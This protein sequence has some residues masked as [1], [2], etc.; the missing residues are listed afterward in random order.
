MLQGVGKMSRVIGIVSGKGGVGKTFFAINLGLALTEIG[1]N[2]IVADLDLKTSSLGLQL[3]AYSFP[4]TIQDALIGRVNILELI[5]IHPSGLRYIPASVSLNYNIDSKNLREIIS[6]L[7]SILL[8][9][10]P[11]GIGEEVLNIIQSCDELI[12]VTNPEVHAVVQSMKIAEIIENSGKSIL[13]LVVNR[14][15]GESYELR[16]EEIS[17]A[18]G[19]KILSSIPED[20]NVIK[21][22]WKKQP[23]LQYKPNSKVSVEFKKLACLL[24][25]KTY[26][27]PRFLVLRGLVREL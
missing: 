6:P 25:G 15:R 2:A 16:L 11:P 7:K 1:E 19:I 3:G 26:K 21:S 4:S 13:G 17:K 20:S 12:I 10:S 18:T 5:Y 23:I 8:I 22:I 9:D 24:T 14:I 27:K